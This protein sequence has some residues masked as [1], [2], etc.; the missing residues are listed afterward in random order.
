MGSLSSFA[1]NTL[2]WCGCPSPSRPL[3]GSCVQRM[4]AARWQAC[5]VA[6]GSPSVSRAR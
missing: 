1:A 5:L 2:L 6:A 3:E 4:H